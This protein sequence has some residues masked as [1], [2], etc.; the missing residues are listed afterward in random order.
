MDSSQISFLFRSLPSLS[1]VY[2]KPSFFYNSGD[3]VRGMIGRNESIFVKTIFEFK[4]S[5]V[6]VLNKLKCLLLCGKWKHMGIRI[7]QTYGK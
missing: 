2:T 4:E 6:K 1:T 3:L 7:K 5:H